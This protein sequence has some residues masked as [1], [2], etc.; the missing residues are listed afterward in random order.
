MSRGAARPGARRP[1]KTKHQHLR[2]R[3]Y[4]KSRHDPGAT[5]PSTPKRSRVG[6]HP[7]YVKG[8]GHCPDVAALLAVVDEVWDDALE[9]AWPSEVFYGQ[10]LEPRLVARHAVSAW[11]GQ[12]RRQYGPEFCASRGVEP[13]VT[14]EFFGRTAN[15]DVTDP[16][17]PLTADDVREAL[18]DGWLV[19]YWTRTL[20]A[21]SGPTG[22]RVASP[23]EASRRR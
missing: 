11:V 12:W 2:Q 16:Y 9:A 4:R 10:M 19:R 18:A 14:L 20:T 23:G 13:E 15:P 17:P 8:Y 5:T 21:G 22:T 7:D 1:R 3:D 6:R